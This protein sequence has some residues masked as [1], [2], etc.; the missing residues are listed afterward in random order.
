MGISKRSQG[1]AGEIDEERGANLV[2]F[3]ILAP[4]LIV[5]VFGIVDFSWVFAQNLGVRSGAREAARI[6]AV[7]F[8]DGA[9]ILGEVCAR[10]DFISNVELLIAS[11]LGLVP[12][13]TEYNPGDEVTT[14]VTSDINTLTGLFDSFFPSPFTLSSS[15]SIRIEQVQPTQPNNNPNWAGDVGTPVT[16]S[17]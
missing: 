9:A 13:A 10:T 2:E 15:V 17:C 1:A 5:L 3:A 4:L 14:T 16:G 6:A 12:G 7:D 11:D 8:G